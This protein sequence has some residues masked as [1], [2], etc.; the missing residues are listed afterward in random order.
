[1]TRWRLL[2][3]LGLYFRPDFLEGPRCRHWTA[4]LASTPGESAEVFA[5]QGSE[6]SKSIRNAV[7]HQPTRDLA[8]DISARLEAL[9][10]A[11]ADHFKVP[12]SAPEPVSY[13][14]YGPGQFYK[15]HS[16]RGRPGEHDAIDRA[17]SVVVFLNDARGPAG[18][19]FD[20][21]QLIFYDLIGGARAK[22]VGLPLEPEA[23]L[24]VAF[25]AEIV[26]EVAP[27]T[28]GTRAVVVTWF[29][30]AESA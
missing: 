23:G 22:G 28:R 18:L 2:A 29:H 21:G 4:E 17:I 7:E 16:D 6:A 20:G 10:P 25:P 26:H 11:V 8:A 19:A 30:H 12:L 9:R 1:M 5:P 15:P 14:T 24:L 27:V 13:L 3:R